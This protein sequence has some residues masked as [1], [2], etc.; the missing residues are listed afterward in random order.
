MRSDDEYTHQ[1]RVLTI[2]VL[3]RLAGWF[4]APE[5]GGDEA[6][7]DRYRRDLGHDIGHVPTNEEC[8]QHLEAQVV[9]LRHSIGE[10][11]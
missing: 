1:D 3:A 10:R 11:W 4:L 7:M 6:M 9:R 2:G 5:A 8:H